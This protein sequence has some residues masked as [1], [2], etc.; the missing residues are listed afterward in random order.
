MN[1][2]KFSTKGDKLASCDSNGIVK[3]WD[4]KTGS[5]QLSFDCDRSSANCLGIDRSG[6]IIGVGCDDGLIRLFNSNTG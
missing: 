2:C 1:G 6:T 5:E 3:V 4:L